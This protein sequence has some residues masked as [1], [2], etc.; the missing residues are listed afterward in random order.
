MTN[1]DRPGHSRLR[2]VVVNLAICLGLVSLPELLATALLRHPAPLGGDALRVFR[3]YY[4]SYDR[5]IIQ[6]LPDCAVYDP[7]LTYRLR[8]GGCTIRNREHRVEYKV[9][10]LGARDDEA[11]LGA[12]EVIAIGDSQA[13]GWGVPQAETFAEWLEHESGRKVLNLAISSYGTVRELRLL[14]RAD[15]SR[16]KTLIIQ[17]CQNDKEENLTFERE[18]GKLPISD[19]AAYEATVERHLADSAYYPG[20]HTLRLFQIWRH[21]KPPGTPPDTPE[22]HAEEAAAFLNALSESGADLGGVEIVV[23]E[24]NSF[25][26]NDSHFTVAL[27]H[28]IE[29]LPAESPWRRIRILDLSNELTAAKYYKLDDH[30]TAEGH[31]AVARALLPLVRVTSA[32]GASE[33]PD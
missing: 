20:K 5:K 8:P 30:L 2:I 3:Q 24:V 15:T 17:Y 22:A 7:E 21:L 28:A 1:S 27:E 6:F 29:Q 14:A 13:M 32:Y 25:A 26:R 10:S 9:N 12:P 16:L 33:A 19:R 23:F 11:S 4:A 18:G 31:R